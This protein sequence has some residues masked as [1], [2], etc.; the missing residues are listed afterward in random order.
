MEF[1]NK[2]GSR[3]SLICTCV[4]KSLGAVAKAVDGVISFRILHGVVG[5][6]DDVEGQEEAIEAAAAT[7]GWSSECDASIIAASV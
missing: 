5:C 7:A 1:P 6:N 4:N 2:S 3:N